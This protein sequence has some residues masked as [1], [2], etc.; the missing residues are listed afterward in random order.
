MKGNARWNCIQELKTI[1]AEALFI[2][3]GESIQVEAETE[4]M[5]FLATVP[6]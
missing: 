5:F 6:E 2:A 4:T 1:G 3:A